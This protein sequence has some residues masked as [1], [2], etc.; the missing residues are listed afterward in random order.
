MSLN[1]RGE[2]EVV[3]FLLILFSLAIIVGFFMFVFPAM[4]PWW[5][6]KSGQAELAQAEQNR[7]IAVLEATAK[8]EAATQLAQ[9]EI[10]R[11]KGVAEANRIIGD[12]LKGNEDYLRYLYIN[13][14]T[15]GEHGREIIYI[16]RQF[17][18]EIAEAAE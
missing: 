5:A 2:S 3:I 13:G 7:Q 6:S 12:S 8:R 14:I 10:E 15:E 11:A 1:K 16:P 9:A 17:C 4:K 18:E